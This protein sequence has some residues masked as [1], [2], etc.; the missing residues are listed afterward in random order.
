MKAHLSMFFFKKY[1]PIHVSS[2]KRNERT[3]NVIYKKLD[4][5]PN[6]NKMPY[7]K[8]YVVFFVYKR[9]NDLG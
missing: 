5:N 3:H 1:I 6:K 4:L 7:N 8:K 2:P 9:K